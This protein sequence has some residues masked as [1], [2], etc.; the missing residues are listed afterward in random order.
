MFMTRATICFIANRSRYFFSFEVD[1][2]EV[3]LEL[4]F[5]LRVSLFSAERMREIV[6]LQAG[7][8]GNQIGAKVSY[9][10][11]NFWNFCFTFD[12]RNCRLLSWLIAQPFHRYSSVLGSHLGRTRN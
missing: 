7:Q 9:V 5:S 6:H 3:G 2:S 10:E 4:F 1:F 8:C 11:V 12:V